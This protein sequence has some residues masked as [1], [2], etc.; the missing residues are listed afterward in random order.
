MKF[1][2]MLDATD[3]DFA[4]QLK[5][6]LGVQD[7][8]TVVISTPQFDRTDG[9]VI[10]YFPRT[11]AE[12]DALKELPHDTLKKI[13]LGVWAEGHYLYPKEWYWNIPAGYMVDVISDETE[14]FVP[15][16]TDDDIRF[17]YLAYGFKVEKK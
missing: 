15:G 9:C 10:T 17:G 5:A 12:F 4:N 3:P 6:A 8:D 11:V 16:E 7:G 2:L 1:D 14:P 13:G